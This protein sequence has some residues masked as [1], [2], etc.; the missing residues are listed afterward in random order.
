[1]V[2]TEESFKDRVKEVTGGKGVPVVFDSVGAATFEDS[3]DCLA[4]FGTFVSFGNASG[5]VP[6]FNPGI[7]SQ[8][9]SLYFTRPTLMSHIADPKDMKE[10]AGWL[11]DYVSGGLAIEVN[12][13][14]PLKQAAAAH[15][16]L[17]ARETTGSTVL[18]PA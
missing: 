7:L 14:F 9:G 6:P 4:P 5:P 8:K 1:M 15:R 3:L 10:L 13:R 17:E 12:Q 2:Y 11:F 18:L 16:A